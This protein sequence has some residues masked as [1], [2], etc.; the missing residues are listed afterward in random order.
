MHSRFPN[1]ITRMVG[2]LSS[3]AT[4]PASAFKGFLRKPDGWERRMLRSVLNPSPLN[5]ANL[6]LLKFDTM[7]FVA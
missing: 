5:N 4:T 6:K 3:L 2:M 7:W 1:S